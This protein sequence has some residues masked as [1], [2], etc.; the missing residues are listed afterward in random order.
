MQENYIGSVRFYKNLILLIVIIMILTPSVFA[1]YYKSHYLKLKAELN[2]NELGTE[3][4]TPYADLSYQSLY[5]DF[6][7][8][9]PTM[10]AERD[11]KT[12]FLTFDDGPSQRTDE[13]LAILAEKD[14]KATFFV[15][16]KSDE[17]SY[18]RLRAIV[19]QGHTLAMHSYSHDYESI[20]SSVEAYLTDMYQVFDM[21]K[22]ETGTAPTLYRFPGGSIN[23]YNSGIYEELIAEMTRRGFIAHDWNISS[24]DAVN[25]LPSK[26]II[27]NN[28]IGQANNKT[29]GIVLMHD[30]AGKATTVAALPEMIDS[31]KEKGFVFDKLEQEDA[32]IF[33][34]YRK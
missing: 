26:N 21:I 4:V 14:V 17:E 3:E 22:R 2:E 28:V 32:P 33:F 9:P 16:G 34:G 15:V 25:T 27:L 1:T 20:Y 13:I 23:A 18:D 11:E 10:H 19:E 6:Y 24:Q 7:V 30:S 31:L 29:Y 8:D 12:I 5:P